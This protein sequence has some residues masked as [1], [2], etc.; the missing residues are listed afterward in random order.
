MCRSRTFTFIIYSFRMKHIPFRFSFF[1]AAIVLFCITSGC[2]KESG[3]AVDPSDENYIPKGNL[4]D[5]AYNPMRPDGTI[6]SSYLPILKWDEVVYDFGTI[7]Q[8]EIVEKKYTFKNI[9]TAPLLILNATSTC[10]CTI[11]DWPKNHILPDSS[12]TVLVKFNSTNKEGP[13]NKEVTIFANTIP[14]Q[15]KINIKGNVEKSK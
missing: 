12:G 13:Q 4:A 10:G 3:H 8:G 6:D 7:H 5:L 9:G 15:S 2:K 1:F 11:P 14:N